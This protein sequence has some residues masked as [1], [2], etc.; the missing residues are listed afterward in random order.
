[1]EEHL[2]AVDGE[3]PGGQHRLAPLPGP[4]ALGDA[5]DEQIGDLI[6]GEITRL[7]GLVVVP[8]LPA[9]LGHRRLREQQPAGLVLER[10]F[11]VADRQAAR[12]HLHRQVLERFAVALEMVAQRRAERLLE[13]GDLRGRILEAALG[14]LQALGPVA[15]AVA[16]TRG[17]AVLVVAAVERV[18][19]LALQRLLD[20]QPGRQRD[21][22]RA[23]RGR[24]QAP[25]DQ[26]RKGFTG[27]HRGGYPPRHGVLLGLGPAPPS[28]FASSTQ[29]MH[30]TPNS[31]QS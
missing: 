23:P 25:F 24:R 7:E 15:V 11:D 29:R 8:K 31:Q 3:A 2:A 12:Q 13:S 28:P 10:V 18:P 9:D 27:A 22:L 19:H 5:V 26:G 16:L 17:G 6:F 14:G 30:P 4:D 21:Q 20:D 1:M